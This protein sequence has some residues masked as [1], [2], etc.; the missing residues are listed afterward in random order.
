VQVQEPKFKLHISYFL[1]NCKKAIPA[2]NDSP[3]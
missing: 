2:K 1:Q 3:Y